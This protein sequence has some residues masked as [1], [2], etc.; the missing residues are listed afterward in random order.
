MTE[1]TYTREGIYI[2]EGSGHT[3]G[4]ILNAK[5]W[6]TKG[7]TVGMK[8]DYRY[9]TRHA[10]LKNVSIG[11]LSTPK[12]LAF[13]VMRVKR[14]M[15]PPGL[16][17]SPPPTPTEDPPNQ[18]FTLNQKLHLRQLKWLQLHL[19]SQLKI[20]LSRVLNCF[21]NAGLRIVTVKK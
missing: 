9:S 13:N 7:S 18:L 17:S 6:R 2:D 10:T 14:Q 21:L 3:A 12:P 8:Q 19:M 11:K 5:I 16:T 1:E 20:L 4:T 15:V